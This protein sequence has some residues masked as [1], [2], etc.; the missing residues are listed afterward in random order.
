MV[1]VL[2]ISDL[3]FFYKGTFFLSKGKVVICN[4]DFAPMELF[5]GGVP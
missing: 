4:R 1:T 3:Q 2:I 5:L